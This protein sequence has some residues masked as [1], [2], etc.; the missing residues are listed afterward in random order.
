MSMIRTEDPYNIEQ[1]HSDEELYHYVDTFNASQAPLFGRHDK[2]VDDT[3]LADFLHGHC[4][5]FQNFAYS[6]VKADKALHAPICLECM[7]QT[8]S[9]HHK[10]FECPRFQSEA[11]DHLLSGIG[12]LETNFHLPLIFGS[13]DLSDTRKHFAE[14]VSLICNNSMFGDELLHKTYRK[15]K[16]NEVGSSSDQNPA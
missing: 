7:D 13:L 6:I 9:V 2:R 14:Q 15:K 11:R 12:V 4:L 5:R 1:L 10:I 16:N 8:D 3:N